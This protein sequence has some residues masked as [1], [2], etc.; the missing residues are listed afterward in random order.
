VSDQTAQWAELAPCAMEGAAIDG[1]LQLA[2][3]QQACSAVLNGLG[4]SAALVPLILDF[5]GRQLI[6]K[7]YSDIARGA[8]ARQIGQRVQQYR[9][10]AAINGA[11]PDAEA[12]SKDWHMQRDLKI[13]NQGQGVAIRWRDGSASGYSLQ[14]ERL[15]YQKRD[16]QV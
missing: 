6:I 16:M 1:R 12:D 15:H 3:D 13:G 7:T 4:G 10:W 9:G 5:D 8:E 14:L 11:G 2:A